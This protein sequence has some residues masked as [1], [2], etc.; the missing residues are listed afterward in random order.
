MEI[1]SNVLEKITIQLETQI[2]EYIETYPA[3]PKILLME[4]ENNR[5][6]WMLGT[7]WQSMS[8]VYEHAQFSF[9]ELCSLIDMI[10]GVEA[11]QKFI[12]EFTE[13]VKRITDGRVQVY[14]YQNL[15]N[16]KEKASCANSIA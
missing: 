10:C 12:R 2:D 9:L 5:E 8:F 3:E 6:F 14:I 15:E 7:G 1:V 11:E 4:I 16:S 13:E